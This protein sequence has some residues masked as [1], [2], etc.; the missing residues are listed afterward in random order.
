MSFWYDISKYSL[1]KI[2]I[3]VCD[4]I[5]LRTTA[6]HLVFCSSNYAHPDTD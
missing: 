5:I 3:L 2:H 1:K 4:I 6:E